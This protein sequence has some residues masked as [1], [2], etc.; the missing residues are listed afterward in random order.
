MPRAKSAQPAYQ[1]HFSGQARVTLD[2]KDFYLGKHSS[3]ESYAKYYALL[4]EYNANGRKAPQPP[5][6]DP[7]KADEKPK[8]FLDAK[9]D[10]EHL[11][12]DPT[13]IRG[14]T[15]DFRN[16]VLVKYDQ[17]KGHYYAFLRVIEL[18][19]K[20]HGDESPDTFGPRKLEAMRDTFV[21]RNLSRTYVNEL[22]T[23]VIRI[24]RH[25]VSRELVLPERIVALESLPALKR[26]ECREGKKRPKVKLETV[27][28]TLPLLSKVVQD[29]VKLQ[30]ATAMRPSEMFRMTLA[31]IDRSG[32]TWF[33]RP[34]SHKTEHHE[35]QKA[36]ALSS[37]AV[38]ILQPYLS[39]G[40]KELLFRTRHGNPWNKDAYCRAV[41]RA[42]EKG[43]IE[44]WT[45]YALRHAAAQYVRDAL[46]AEAAQ[47]ILGHSR[48]STTEIYAQASEALAAKAAEAIPAVG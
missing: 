2:G 15:A 11:G 37:Q 26:G 5:A 38:E 30:L 42:C 19:E 40:K 44:R 3:P 34:D 9:S 14:V 24:F 8:C 22:V 28:L 10:A 33:Y 47:A 39:R 41:V 7:E 48:L 35:K 25:G 43:M 32:E 6:S 31:Q 1:F 27:K 4:A 17:S 18:L 23:K 36:I 13:C 20:R 12:D 46:G 29:M 45:P 16:R 21:A